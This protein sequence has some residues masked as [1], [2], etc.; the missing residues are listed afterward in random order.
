MW[1]RI[2]WASLLTFLEVVA[3]VSLVAL[4][5]V[6]LLGR[7]LCRTHVCI[8]DAILVCCACAVRRVFQAEK[9][10]SARRCAA[11]HAQLLSAVDMQM[12]LR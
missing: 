4:P 7:V 12:S 11:K 8:Y 5:W 10:A 3:A 6:L 2:F 9:E 1:L